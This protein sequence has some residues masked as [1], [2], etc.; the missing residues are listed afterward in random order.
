MSFGIDAACAIISMMSSPPKNILAKSARFLRHEHDGVVSFDLGASGIAGRPGAFLLQ[1]AMVSIFCLPLGVV[2]IATLSFSDWQ[3]GLQIFC[4]AIGFIATFVSLYPIFAT[5]RWAYFRRCRLQVSASGFSFRVGSP[6][7]S[8]CVQTDSLDCQ[9]DRGSGR[10]KGLKHLALDLDHL[11]L[12]AGSLEVRFGSGLSNSA[13]KDLA[14]Q[15]H[16]AVRTAKAVGKVDPGK[17]VEWRYPMGP[18]I[19]QRVMGLLK[20]LTRPF[21]QPAPYAFCDLISLTGGF[22]LPRLLEGRV[23]LGTIYPFAFALY[24]IGLVVRRWDA[25]YL[26]GLSH[27]DKRWHWF[28]F[29]YVGTPLF[30]GLGAGFSLMRVANDWLPGGVG[31]IAALLLPP[32][33]AVFVHLWVFKKRKAAVAKPSYRW[34]MEVISLLTLAPMAILH[35]HLSFVF[36]E[37]TARRL[38]I[39]ALP[40]VVPVV[41]ALYLPIRLHYFV[42]SPGD[43][44]NRLWF[45]LTIASISIYSVFGYAP[46]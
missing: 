4:A 13:L 31:T 30:T 33:L 37:G 44:T 24:L 5:L 41:G 26:S 2:G 3:T 25:N 11:V 19:S 17:D 28:T 21:R 32:A 6:L 27:Y 7:W 42:E 9:L 46:I 39:L 43:R 45:G 35:E 36:F 8:K 16:E 22:L 12:R 1:W 18:S 40:M 29:A 23:A 15:I 34:G 20:D 38:F 14:K 10:P